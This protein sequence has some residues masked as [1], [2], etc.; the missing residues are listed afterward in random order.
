MMK[1]LL[2]EVFQYAGADSGTHLDFVR[3]DPMYRLNFA[4][5]SINCSSDLEKTREEIRR[6]RPGHESFLQRFFA[7]EQKRFSYM[8][9]CLKKSY[10]SLSS[11]FSMD[12]LKAAP[13]LSLG[14]TVFQVLKGYFKDDDLAL[15][16]SF[17]SKYLG[18]SAWE[19][20]GAFAMLA[21][22]EYAFGVYHTQ[23]GLSE[24]SRA[25]AEVAKSNGATLFYETPVRS[26]IVDNGAARG[27]VL[28]DGERRA[29][30]DVIINADFC[31]AM[32]NLVPQ[33]VLRK[34]RP[35]KLRNKKLSCST[36]MLYLGLDKIYDMPHHA[37]Y[38]AHQY[39]SNVE[40]IFQRGKL[41][42]D[43]S[44]YVRNASVT[45]PSLAPEGHSAVYVLVPVPNLRASIN[46]A[47]QAEAFRARVLETIKRRCAIPDLESHI[48]EEKVI[49]PEG[50]RDDYFVYQGATFNLGHQVSQMLYL[51]PRNKFE[52][53]DNCWLV[54]G[55]THPGSGVPTILESGRITSDMLTRRYKRT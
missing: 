38:M 4:D 51:R 29:Y 41:S 27:V 25:M 33:G 19:C 40:D 17:Q 45:D 30:D 43:I 36:F 3:L 53:I 55:G 15:A 14:K 52:E 22:I 8:L 2:D 10:S 5:F 11:F 50:W 7:S 49:T 20:P 42:D 1:P 34:Y 24:L 23:G 46:W 6:I 12:L 18:M 21:Y 28:S 31:W 9:P 54:G 48:I 35:E 39:R 16:F 47:E 13:H 32:E 26:L 44:F 37:I